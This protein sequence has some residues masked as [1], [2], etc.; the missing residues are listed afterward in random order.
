MKKL[1]LLSLF[2]FLA[3]PS[4]VFASPLDDLKSDLDQWLGSGASGFLVWQYSG[5]KDKYFENDPYSFYEGSPVC[6][7]LKQA[8]TKYPDKFIGVNIHSLANHPNA[9]DST[10]QY[11]S[12]ECGVKVIRVWATPDRGNPLPVLNA[13]SSHGIQVILVLADYSNSS[14]DIL[15]GDIRSNPTSWYTS[16]YKSKYLPYVKGV[17]STL[18]S[19]PALF[20]Y[21]LANEP[22]CSGIDVCRGPYKLW[23]NDVAQQIKTIDPNVKVSIGQKSSENTTLGD[24]PGNGDFKNSNDSSY[25]NLTSAHYYNSAEKSLASQAQNQSNQLNKPFYLGE[26]GY[27]FDEIPT[28]SSLPQKKGPLQ[29]G[30]NPQNP[31]LSCDRTANPEYHPLRPYPGNACDPLIP[32]SVPEAPVTSEKKF[33]TFACGTSLTPSAIERFDP[34]GQN[35][36][37]EN[38]PTTY[39]SAHTICDPVNPNS[40]TGATANCWRSE[41]FDI[42]LDLSQA[43]LGILGNTQDNSLTDAQKVNEYLSWYLTGT[44]QIGDQIPLNPN[45]PSQIDRLVNFAG[46][47]RKLLPFDLVATARD[48]VISSRGEDVHNYMVG[49]NQ[50]I[51]VNPGD[52]LNAIKQLLT[53][54]FRNAFDIAQIATKIVEV[55]IKNLPAFG[56]A[57]SKAVGQPNFED[58]F[59]TFFIE[60]GGDEGVRD[61]AFASAKFIWDRLGSMGSMAKNVGDAIASVQPLAPDR[62]VACADANFATAKARLS[63]YSGLKGWLG[64]LVKTDAFVKLLQNVPFSSLEDTAGEVTVSVFRDPAAEQQTPNIADP[65]SRGGK[66]TAP[67]QLIIKKAN[68]AQ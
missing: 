27:K 31:D 4:L 54:G 46:P 14:G 64:N 44:P 62:A 50:V 63:D 67:L 48:T 66:S 34:Y 28:G 45:S 25:I 57:L 9:L 47:L 5:P 24:S 19:H 33:N 68:L 43:N 36:Y 16:D 30:F 51:N 41:A 56:R 8:A 55:D 21:E 13:A 58:K 61:R 15:P 3:W 35:G 32:R 2:S 23:A 29:E 60:L 17:V 37:Y 49:C 1:F 11:L 38:L 42:T 65:V 20:G 7:V 12:S 40:P 52:Y 26:I 22:H 18:K 10:F 59:K 6:S 53:S 39:G